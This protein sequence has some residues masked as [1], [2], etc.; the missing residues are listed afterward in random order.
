MTPI[1]DE[2]LLAYALDEGL[3][4][5]QRR[6][7]AEAL[8]ADP[9][10]RAQLDRVRAALAAAGASLARAPELGFEARLWA[11]IAP[12]LPAPRARAPRRWPPLAL[13]ASLIVALALGVLIG[14]QQTP[15]PALLAADAG[16]R[17][18]S[19][20]LTRHLDSAGALLARVSDAAPDLDASSLARELIANNRLYALAAER[21]GRADLARFLREL[22]PQLAALIANGDGAEGT[23]LARADWSFKAR[24]AADAERRRDAHSPRDI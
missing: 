7:I 12:A 23:A 11:R 10:L 8:L 17:I 1:D 16:S 13:A 21:A 3:D 2:L 4:P 5:H 9:A 24:I 6:R 20:H 14:R 19:A 22:E 15:A 18:L